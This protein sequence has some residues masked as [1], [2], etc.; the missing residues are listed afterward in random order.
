MSIPGPESLKRVTMDSL[1]SLNINISFS[2][3][4]DDSL[5]GSFTSS[6]NSSFSYSQPETTPCSSRRPSAMSESWGYEY[7]P[8]LSVSSRRQTPPASPCTQPGLFSLDSFTAES[9]IPYASCNDDM[10]RLEEYPTVN[11]L[12]G[13]V[14]RGLPVGYFP[15]GTH[16]PPWACGGAL[17]EIKYCLRESDMTSGPVSIPISANRVIEPEDLARLGYQSAPLYE[18]GQSCYYHTQTVLSPPL[19]VVPSQTFNLPTTDKLSSSSLYTMIKNEWAELP[20][21]AMQYDSPVGGFVS[22]GSMYCNPPS[23][24]SSTYA[25]EDIVAE[26]CPKSKTKG[27]RKHTNGASKKR[28]CM[29]ND[30]PLTIEP[31]Q[32]LKC[33]YI[34]PKKG[35]CKKGFT[36][37]EHRKRHEFSH[38]GLKPFRCL[39]P[40]CGKMLNRSDNFNT[41]KRTH[42]VPNK[43]KRNEHIEEVDAVKHGLGEALLPARTRKQIKPKNEKL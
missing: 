18:D 28:V 34:D 43:L 15:L 20:G 11:R 7:L 3:D 17:G 32:K 21:A 33:R 23:P 37:P 42:L 30:I 4:F 36:R 19:T 31:V 10:S 8:S 16:I 26:F 14:D 22:E 12:L 13:E 39:V 24:P 5:Y 41:H 1:S 6:S 40:G 25:T 35:P 29:I 38:T 9:R 2:E 27:G